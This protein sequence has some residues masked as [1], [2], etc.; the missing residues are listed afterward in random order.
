M[1]SLAVYQRRLK[2]LQQQ[3]NNNQAILVSK[4]TDIFYLVNFPQLAPS[5]REA[6]LLVSPKKTALFHH[7]FSPTL[8]QQSWLKT[9]PTTDLDKVAENIGDNVS[10]LIIDPHTLSVAEQRE[11]SDHWS[12]KLADLPPQWLWELRVTKDQ[13]ESKS[14]RKAAKIAQQVMAQ[15]IKQLKPGMTEKEVVSLILQLMLKAGSEKPAF[16]IIVAFGAAGALPHYQPKNVKLKKEMPVLI[17][18]GATVDGYCSD[19]T[20]TVWLGQRPSEEFLKVEKIVRNAYQQTV[21]LLKQ[22]K[23][24]LTAKELDDAAREVISEAGFAKEFIH[25]TGH[26]LGLEIHEPPSLSWNN[27]QA[28]KPHMAITI[29]PGIYLPGKFGY[30]YENTWLTTKTGAVNLTANSNE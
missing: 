15:A 17:D 2:A 30:R 6:F 25:T 18:L 16:P 3:L 4:P 1:T 28:I 8:S 9:I 23:K 19:M 7:R 5:E 12:G 11:L 24:N 14:L 20:R 13:T 29:E 22:S 10:E 21:K 26:G 27:E